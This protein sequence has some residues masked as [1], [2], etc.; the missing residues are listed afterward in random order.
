VIAR[1]DGMPP[2]TIGL[3]ASGKLT[4]DDYRDV[5]EPALAEGI[6]SGELRLLFVLTDFDGL[7]PGAWA[8]DVKTGARA[9]GRDHSAWKRLALVTD[10]D[11]V[12]TATR[13]FAW[14]TPGEVLVRG[15]DGLDEAKAWVAA[16]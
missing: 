8:E 11:W 6:G 13:T 9:M 4:R 3:T 10:V 15:L 1:M 2:G 16:V 12:A 7:E 14:M 5:L